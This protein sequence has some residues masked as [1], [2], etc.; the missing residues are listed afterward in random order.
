[1]SRVAPVLLLLGLVGC[2]TT[3]VHIFVAYRYDAAAD[4]LESRAGVDVIDGPDPGMCAAVR[5]WLSLGGDVYVTD[6]ACDGPIDYKDQTS[7]MSGACVKALAAYARD[8]HGRCAL[9]DGGA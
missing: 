4:C 9:A 7:D 5:C 8:G 2:T 6:T 3:H 1:V